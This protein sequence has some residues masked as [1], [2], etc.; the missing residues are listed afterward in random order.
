MNLWLKIPSFLWPSEENFEKVKDVSSA[1]LLIYLLIGASFYV[2]GKFLFFSEEADFV[3][4]TLLVV[5]VAAILF[6][7]FFVYAV[8]ARIL[9]WFFGGEGTLK[10]AFNVIVHAFTPFY[11]F[12][13]VPA[14]GYFAL[15]VTLANI[16][17]GVKGV[18]RLS[19]ARAIVVA[20]LP[21]LLLGVL[22]MIV[23][24]LYG[25]SYTSE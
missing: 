20:V 6:I 7:M 23:L 3:G 24:F 17:V 10:S 4:V 22:I 15:L 1:D 25:V 2:F 8:L 16:S 14:I 19:G 9:V 13:W 12:G 21:P 18:F 5:F 11:L